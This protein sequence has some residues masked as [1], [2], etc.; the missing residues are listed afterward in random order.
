MNRLI[1]FY[2]KIPFLGALY[3]EAGLPLYRKH[4][5]SIN[6][7]NKEIIVDFPLGEIILTPWQ[8]VRSKK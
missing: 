6:K 3:V 4:L 5:Y 1:R 7:W 2:L 8:N